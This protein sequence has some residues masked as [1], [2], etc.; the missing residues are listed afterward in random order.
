MFVEI[1][2]LLHNKKLR[3]RAEKVGWFQGK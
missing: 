2:S 3:R 1:L